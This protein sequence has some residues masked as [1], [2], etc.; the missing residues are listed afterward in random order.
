MKAY[1]IIESSDISI[2]EYSMKVQSFREGLA[3][4]SNE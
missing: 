1:I 4:Y 3:I 2:K